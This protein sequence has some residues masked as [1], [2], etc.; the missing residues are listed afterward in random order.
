[1]TMEA[2]AIRSDKAPEET[3]ESSTGGTPLDAAHETARR[4]LAKREFEEAVEVLQ[5]LVQKGSTSD[6]TYGLLGTSFV[7][8]ERYRE[9]KDAFVEAVNRNPKSAEWAEKLGKAASALETRADVERP[10]VPR[11]PREE[12]LSAPSPTDGVLP[13]AKPGKKPS[14]T[15]RLRKQVGDVLGK[16]AGEVLHRVTPLISLVGT[17]DEVWTNWYRRPTAYAIVTLAYMRDQLN[18]RNLK[19][20]YPEGELTAFQSR[21][22]VAPESAKY[23]RTAD[24]SWNNLNNPREGSANTRFPRNVDRAVTW[25]KKAALLSPNPAEISQKLFKR[26]DEGMKP[27]PFLNLLAAAW[28]QFN[29]HDWVSHRSDLAFGAHEVPLPPDHPARLKYY[30][31]TMFVGRTE[32]DAGRKPSDDGSP[33]TYI[34]EVTSWWDASQIYGSDQATADRLRSYSKGKLKLGEDGLLPVGQWGFEDTGFN[35]NW[36]LG[37]SLLHTVFVKEHNAICEMLARAY[38]D[39]D[40]NRLYHVARLINAAVIAKIHTVEWTP[41]I[42]P[43]GTLQQAMNAN[44]YGLL[45]TNAY[46]RE[47]RKVFRTIKVRNPEIGGI[48]GNDTE[49]HGSP[50]GLSDEFT[51]I[52]RLHELLP[53]E[54]LL[55]R[56]GRPGEEK[57]RLA[58][59]RFDGACKVTKRERIADLLYSFGNINP[60][61]LVLRNYPNTLRELA[62]PGNPMYDLAAVDILRARERGVPRYNEFRRQL[63]LNPIRRFEDLTDDPEIVGELKRIYENDLEAIDLIVGTRAESHR[64]TGYGFGETMFQVFILNASRRLQADRFYTESYNAETYTAEGLAWID[65]TDFKGVLLR[66]YPELAETGLANVNNGFEPWDAGE[67]DLTRHPLDAFE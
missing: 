13:L 34:N 25:P 14:L 10:P 18:K 38:P 64:P 8:L 43:N 26:A 12:L 24:G 44:W 58:E 46:K 29:V 3:R 45:E 42:L 19:D 30:Q 32:S 28:I 63:G 39:W 27:V 37:L 60:G 41:A 9:A 61:Q 40:D 36:W 62:L 15:E 65:A 49:K 16:G 17:A 67:R 35:R 54:L 48:V 1:M 7:L 52:Y 47:D 11:H 31:T 53:D 4:L 66:H 23:F 51:E 55:R 21:G 59:V 20:T 6:V 56:I 57:L 33:P 22:L 50:Y 5:V 2:E